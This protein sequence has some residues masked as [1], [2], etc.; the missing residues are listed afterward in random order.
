MTNPCHKLGSES[1][2]RREEHSAPPG[3]SR[4]YPFLQHQGRPLSS[5]QWK[6]RNKT[7]FNRDI[8][9]EDTEL[10]AS[11]WKLEIGGIQVRIYRTCV[12]LMPNGLKAQGSWAQQSLPLS[13]SKPPRTHLPLVHR[14]VALPLPDNDIVWLCLGQTPQ[15]LNRSIPM[16]DSAQDQQTPLGGPKGLG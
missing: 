8:H 11:S 7:F 15:E 5:L 10:R 12:I 16:G 13:C 1:A 14:H 2:E 6:E 9:V 4:W 3:G